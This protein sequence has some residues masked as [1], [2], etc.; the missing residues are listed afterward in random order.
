MQLRHS[1]K[2][3]KQPSKSTE[4][5]DKKPITSH[6]SVWVLSNNIRILK[7]L[8]LQPLGLFKPPDIEGSILAKSAGYNSL[9][10]DRISDEHYIKIYP[11]I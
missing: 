2:M 10:Y 9:I 4:Y 5:P 11:D 6:N 7:Y 3:G 8:K 1:A